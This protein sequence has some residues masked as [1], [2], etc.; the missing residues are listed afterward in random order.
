MLAEV[1]APNDQ[2]AWPLEF[3]QTSRRSR[4]P[5]RSLP[6]GVRL[7]VINTGRLAC[8]LA[9]ICTL[10]PF[11]G[12]CPGQCGDTNRIKSELSLAACIQ[13]ALEHNLDIKIERYN[14]SI[15]R[16]NLNLAY[17]AYEPSLSGGG[18]HNF[19]LSP[20]GIDPQNRPFPGTSTESE[21][22]NA[23]ISGLLPSGLSYVLGGNLT[24][25][26]G[27]APG[28][29]F[30]NTGG[31][32]SIQLRQPLLRNAWIDSSRLAIRVNR[33]LLKTSELA[34]RQQIMS[35][36][37]EVQ[38]AYY[39]LISAN[40]TLSVQAEALRLAERL[41]NE[42]QNRVA[43]GAMAKL[44]EKQ[45]ASQ[46]AARQADLLAAERQLAAQKNVLKLL[47]V[48]DTS[49]WRA[50]SPDPSETLSAAPQTPNVNDSWEKAFTLRPD[51]LQAR[52]DLERQGIVIKFLKNQL[53]PQLDLVG[54]YGH[55]A[56]RR[57]F[58]GALD[59]LRQGDSPFYS[60]GAMITIPLG[61]GSG[62]NN[63]K[64][65]KAQ[66][67]Q[68]LLKVKR[69]ELQIMAQVEDAV[70]VVQT[71]LRR[72]E[73]TKQARQFAE[74]ALEAEQKKLQS[75]KSTSF[76]VL[77]FQRDLTAARSAEVQALADYNKA[78]AELAFDEGTTLEQNRLEVKVD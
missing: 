20:G 48:D 54:S 43:A 75:G 25:A 60:Y 38:F 55:N 74:T 34:L 17:A 7:I 2:I 3:D 76:F 31:A 4:M 8:I 26:A 70:K 56:S 19:N 61:N 27:V 64:V 73:A 65:G 35:T 45:A 58:S 37:R 29:P 67:Q 72:V 33:K 50:L 77:Q 42:D 9:R 22:I 63:Y 71:D 5:R 36:V 69:L 16:Y 52:T 51:L 66:V 53:F 57:E 49:D 39:D 40:Q 21:S 23:G 11:L 18:V 6:V 28:G 24:D 68:S 46:V 10:L 47:L 78:L 41:L 62:R 32:A 59:E 15:A 30:E 12:V 14:P 13:T 44:D 1:R